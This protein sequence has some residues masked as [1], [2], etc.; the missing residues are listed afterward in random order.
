MHVWHSRPRLCAFPDGSMA[1]HPLRNLLGGVKEWENTQNGKLRWV[2]IQAFFWL[3]RGSL[4]PS[5]VPCGQV[6]HARAAPPS[7]QHLLRP[8]TDRRFPHQHS[9]RSAIATSY[10]VQAQA[11]HSW[12]IAL[13]HKPAQAKIERSTRDQ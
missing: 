7:A 1:P 4:R 11:E 13:L 10:L 3:E 8:S 5:L 9:Q 6:K 12:H 2:P